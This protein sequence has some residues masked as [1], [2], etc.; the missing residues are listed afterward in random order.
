[1]DLEIETRGWKLALR[2]LGRAGS[3]RSRLW[4]RSILILGIASLLCA[5]ETVAQTSQTGGV[6]ANRLQSVEKLIEN[7]SAARQVEASGEPQA[8][9]RRDEA[10]A[11]YK[12]ALAA[13]QAGDQEQ[14]EKLLS[15]ATKTMFEAVRMADQEEVVAEKHA[16]DFDSRLESVNALLEAHDRVSQEKGAEVAN[17]ELRSLVQR[18]LA[19]AQ[20][21]REQGRPEEG[22]KRLDEAYVAA[23]VAIEN[24]RGGDTLVRSLNFETKEEEYRYE[25][26]RNDTHQM[27]IKVL[28][29][30]KMEK[31]GVEQ[32]VQQFMGKAAEAR[33]EAERKAA[34]GDYDGAVSTME[35]STKHLVR[36][37]RSAGIYIPG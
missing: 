13:A 18:K 34:G 5:G 35:E 8:L 4:L 37:I 1:M 30:E 17:G 26:D 25:V 2:T 10:R 33:A 16:R 19:D 3:M 11:L 7:S 36:A 31:A 29:Q 21:L 6:S 24:L 15:Q 20:S 23:K 12:Q 32:M 14:A 28:L 22:R 9:A 27:L